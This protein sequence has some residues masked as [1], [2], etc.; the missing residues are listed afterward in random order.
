MAYYPNDSKIDGL[1]RA[2]RWLA[3]QNIAA[4]VYTGSDLTKIQYNAA[5][6]VDYEV[7]AYTNGDLTS[8]QHYIGSV[9]KGTTT[10]TKSSGTLVSAV[11]TGV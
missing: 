10:L 2:D 4:M 1:I 8:I 9:L 7:L 5:T 3:S 6:N 11:F